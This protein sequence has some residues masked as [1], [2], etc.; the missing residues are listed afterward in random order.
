[1]RRFTSILFLT[2]ATAALVTLGCPL[3]DVEETPR[4]CDG[5][6]ITAFDLVRTTGKPNTISVPFEGYGP[7][8]VN[9]AAGPDGAQ[10]PASASVEVGG[11]PVVGPSDFNGK[12][13]QRSFRVPLLRGSH[14]ATAEVASKPGSTLRV[15]VRSAAAP[16]VDP[17]DPTV[18]ECGAFGYAPQG[19]ACMPA[20]LADAIRAS[21]AP[22]E[23]FCAACVADQ[24]CAFGDPAWPGCM[25]IG[26]GQ[27]DLGPWQISFLRGG[28]ELPL[29]RSDPADPASAI[30]Q[31]QAFEV[32]PATDWTA[33]RVTVSGGWQ[34]WGAAASPACQQ[35][36]RP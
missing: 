24:A 13:W 28:Q 9:I 16:R 14:A 3:D 1:M 26:P 18:V 23:R 17:C 4:T 36:C 8:C 31:V 11:L 2:A 27:R 15:E 30:S 6:L 5:P 20:C 10:A 22:K 29:R 25:Q 35:R 7:L 21:F 34:E 19:G 33:R 12:P 32:L